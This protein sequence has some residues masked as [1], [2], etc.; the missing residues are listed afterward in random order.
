MQKAESDHGILPDPAQRSSSTQE[1]I[2][3][4]KE[5]TTPG[6]KYKIQR[7]EIFTKTNLPPQ[8][9]PV[10]KETSNQ[11]ENSRSALAPTKPPTNEQEQQPTS[12]PG[13]QNDA[14][15]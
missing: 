13:S 14:C 7:P 4:A 10:P 12:T 15:P 11:A 8:S 3:V 6:M 9:E 2:P 1:T 5:S